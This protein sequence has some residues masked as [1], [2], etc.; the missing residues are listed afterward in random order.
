MQ[1]RILN[2]KY[3]ATAFWFLSLLFLASCSTETLFQSNFDTMPVNQAPATMQKVGTVSIDGPNGSVTVID[4]PVTPSDKWVQIKRE[5]NATSVSG[6]QCNFSKFGGDG[7]YTFSSFLYIP[8]GS[9]LVTIQ[10]ETFG[11]PISTYTSFLHLD[12]TEDNMVRLDEN[13]ATKFGA[14][15]RDKPFVVSVNLKISGTS[16]T[17]HIA[18]SGD[19]ASGDKDYTIQSPF[20]TLAHQFGAVRLW[21]G[22]PWTGAFDATTIVVTKKTN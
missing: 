22:F 20:Q 11:Q 4:P 16:Q 5:A 6:M 9:G 8:S 1:T 2:Q 14:F 18:L 3:T 19:G 21:M 7:E 13:D 17:A 15:S 12:F 10:F